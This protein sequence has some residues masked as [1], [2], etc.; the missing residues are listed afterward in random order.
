MHIE[1]RP[2]HWLVDYRYAIYT[3]GV[4]YDTKQARDIPYY[5]FDLRDKLVSEGEQ[6]D[7]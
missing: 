4:V 6:H 7:T 5:I 3:D 1:K 2:N